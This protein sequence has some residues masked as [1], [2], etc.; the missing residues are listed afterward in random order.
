[1]FYSSSLTPLLIQL[2]QKI[3][4]GTL[5]EISDIVESFYS[6][7][8]SIVK[9]MPTMIASSPVIDCNKLVTGA[10]AALG[11]PEN[12]PVKQ[13]ILFLTHFVM[14]S[15][16]FPPMTR[17]VLDQGDRIISIMVTCVAIVAPRTQ[18]ELFADVF[19]AVNKKYPAEFVV[20]MKV[21]QV[22]DYPTPE[23]SPA[24]KKVFMDAL[25][26]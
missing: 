1:M 22:A 10:L 9:K 18:V 4:A 21:L 3:A 24:N 19:L 15:R 14:Q 23:V 12:G 26:K 16:N 7:V 17:A 13:S 2:Q 20:W 6:F 11:M 25:I 8:A 5:S